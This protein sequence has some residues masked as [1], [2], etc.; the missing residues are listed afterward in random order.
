MSAAEEILEQQDAAT[1]AHVALVAK[2]AG[3]GDQDQN[4]RDAAERDEE[5]RLRERYE[6]R[7]LR[8]GEVAF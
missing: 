1:L 4:A 3:F 5:R 6:R 7:R 2:V 8:D